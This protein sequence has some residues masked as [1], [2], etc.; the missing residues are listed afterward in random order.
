LTWTLCL[1]VTDVDRITAALQEALTVERFADS[2]NISA[3]GS[4]LGCRF[5]SML[6]TCHSSTA[7]ES[8]KS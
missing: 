1:G 3:P 4:D 5:S 6:D 2:V 7:S 8:S